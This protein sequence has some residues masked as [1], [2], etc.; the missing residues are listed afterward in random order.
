MLPHWIKVSFKFEIKYLRW[1]HCCHF[2]FNYVCLEWLSFKYGSEFS[3]ETLPCIILKIQTQILKFLEQYQSCTN[4]KPLS[5]LLYNN[6][7]FWLTFC[8]HVAIIDTF[9]Y[10]ELYTICLRYDTVNIFQDNICNVLV[11]FYLSLY[12]NHWDH[13]VVSGC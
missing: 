8:W 2:F 9:L 13:W 11:L 1:Q 5:L 7:C 4:N 10:S 12:S 6:G 3:E